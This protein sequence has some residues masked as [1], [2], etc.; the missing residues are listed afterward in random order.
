MRRREFIKLFGGAAA[1]W[2]S[3]ARAQQPAMPVIGFL[4]GGAAVERMP[5]VAAF[6]RGLNELGYLEGRNLAIEYRW[7]EGHSDRLAMLAADLVRRKVAVFVA[8]GGGAAALAAK[9]ATATIPIV[10]TGGGDPVKLGLVASLN[11]PAGNATGIT[12]FSG[13]L[14]AKR[15]EILRELV[16]TATI[17][18]QLVDPNNPTTDVQLRDVAEAARVLGQKIHVLNAG[19]DREVDIAFATLARVGAGALTVGG[20]ALFNTLRNQI[21]AL[22]ARQGIPTMYFD[23][24]AVAAGGL[25]SYGSDI[26]DGYRQAGIY[27]GRILKGEKPTDLPVQQPTRFELVIN[28]SAAKALGLTVPLTLQASADEVIE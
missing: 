18:A 20:S 21:I 11:R 14:E 23:R 2:P 15:L 26:A 17:I 27:T 13:V 8:T 19:N 9:A 1:A 22:A 5:Y 28:L 6:R 7:G 3:A 25:I 4:N 16:P 12:N 24:Q 10:F